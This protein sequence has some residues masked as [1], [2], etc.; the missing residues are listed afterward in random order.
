LQSGASLAA[1]YASNEIMAEGTM[2]GEVASKRNAIAPMSRFIQGTIE[3]VL[4]SAGGM[5]FGSNKGQSFGDILLKQNWSKTQ[6]TVVDYLADYAA[7]LA[8]ESGKATRKM[9]EMEK[10]EGLLGLAWLGLRR[11]GSLLGSAWD[12]VNEFAKSLFISK[13]TTNT[14]ETLSNIKKYEIVMTDSGYAR[15][16]ANG[17]Y[18]YIDDVAA[19]AEMYKNTYGGEV[20][21]AAYQGNTGFNPDKIQEIRELQGDGSYKVT[22]YDKEGK[23]AQQYYEVKKLDTSKALSYEQ[24]Y[25]LTGGDMQFSDEELVRYGMVYGAVVDVNT[26]FNSIVKEANKLN[27]TGEERFKYII[28][29]MI[30]EYSGRKF[31]D[32][33]HL[34][35]TYSSIMENIAQEFA[36]NTTNGITYGFTED[37]FN[38]YPGDGYM[39]KT[40]NLDCANFVVIG[41]NILGLVDYKAQDANLYYPTKYEYDVARNTAPKKQIYDSNGKLLYEYTNAVTNLLYN[42]SLFKRI[43][44]DDASNM[45][46]TGLIGVMKKKDSY[47]DHVYVNVTADGSKIVDSNGRCGVSGIWNRKDNY[48]NRTKYYLKLKL[49]DYRRAN[50]ND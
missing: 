30:D 39:N 24:A 31:Y 11:A 8:R 28:D 7:A 5:W 18:E 2:A 41:L 12:E 14:I 50:I 37:L 20:V 15:K 9:M 27:L 21:L 26:K 40:K 47:Y 23:I 46:L 42:N 4:L 48:K 45:D 44:K 16:Y 1:L 33:T 36:Y 25:R 35:Y 32:E 29:S 22:V 19:Q 38:D 13:D 6:Y 10:K 43:D 49:P 17:R 34:R 3:N